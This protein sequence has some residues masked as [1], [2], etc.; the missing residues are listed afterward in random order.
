MGEQ[1]E[2]GMP[3]ENEPKEMQTMARFIQH[4]GYISQGGDILVQNMT[5]EEAKRKAATLSDCEGFTYE[6]TLTDKPMCIYFKRKWDLNGSGSGSG[7]TSF[8]R[9][10]EEQRSEI[11]EL[12]RDAEER[13]K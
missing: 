12:R 13:N 5:V 4:D 9:V 10:G 8:Q 2:Q 3:V 7:W 6:G 11:E 1:K